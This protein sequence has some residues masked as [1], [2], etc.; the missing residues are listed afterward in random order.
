M[1]QN[2]QNVNQLSS[3]SITPGQ[4]IEPSV[5]FRMH[6]AHSAKR[7]LFLAD[8]PAKVGL[9][10]CFQRYYCST[11]QNLPHFLSTSLCRG[12]PESAAQGPTRFA[13]PEGTL[14]RTTSSDPPTAG[15]LPLNRRL[16]L[17]GKALRHRIAFKSLPQR[18]KGAVQG[19]VA[20]RNAD[21]RGRSP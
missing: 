9:F 19:K 21:G 8:Q 5:T 10:C 16:R 18:P 11:H 12:R 13:H 7:D 20:A 4:T 1:R 15:H 17:L 2:W 3:G 14:G 6:L